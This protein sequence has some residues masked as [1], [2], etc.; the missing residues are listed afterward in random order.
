MAESPPPLNVQAS[1]ASPSDPVEVSWSPPS[2]GA[3]TI[4]GY[5][6]FYGSGENV[7]LPSLATG[8]SLLLSTN[9]VGHTITLCAEAEA[10][11]SQCVNAT[12]TG[13]K[14]YGLVIIIT[15]IFGNHVYTLCLKKR[16]KLEMI[17][18][19]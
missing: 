10:K 11:M 6:I 17:F 2:N 8:I 19:L 13:T 14:H 16:M 18:L 7:S 4:T 9:Y 15:S 1:Q 3:T 12:V 5:R